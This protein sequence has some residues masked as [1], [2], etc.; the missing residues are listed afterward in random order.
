MDFLVK[1]QIGAL[2]TEQKLALNV[3]VHASHRLL[4]DKKAAFVKV[5]EARECAK[6]AFLYTHICKNMCNK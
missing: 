6:S 2:L 1:Q 3:T 5:N 4:A